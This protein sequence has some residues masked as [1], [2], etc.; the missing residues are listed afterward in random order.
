[1]EVHLVESMDE[2]LRIAIDHEI[3]PLVKSGETLEK[4]PSEPPVGPGSLN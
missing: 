3:A 2:V 4:A 1:M